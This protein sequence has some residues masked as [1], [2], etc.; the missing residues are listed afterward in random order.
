[1]SSN[2]QSPRGAS[3]FFGIMATIGLAVVSLFW[4]VYFVAGVAVLL[5]PRL[6]VDLSAFNYLSFEM[7]YFGYAFLGLGALFVFPFAT[8]CFVTILGT[9]FAIVGYTRNKVICVFNI[10]FG[11]LSFIPF[12]LLLPFGIYFTLGIFL[13]FLFILTPVGWVGFS[14][15]FAFYGSLIFAITSITAGSKGL[16]R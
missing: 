13:L 10:L 12:V 7:D 16:K 3:I 4:C 14:F 9:I 5:I 15:L 11:I 2:S 8:M 6:G 1:M